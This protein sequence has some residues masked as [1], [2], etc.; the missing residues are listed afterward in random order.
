MRWRRGHGAGVIRGAAGFG[1]AGFGAAGFAA[2]GAAFGAAFFGAA[3]A[4]IAF[5]GFAFA[6][7]L[8]PSPSP[9]ASSSLRRSSWRCALNRTA[10]GLCHR[11]FDLRFFDLLFFA[12]IILLL[13]IVRTRCESSPEKVCCH[14]CVSTGVSRRGL[15]RLPRVS[16]TEPIRPL[17]DVWLRPRRVF[18]ELATRPIGAHR[19]LVGSGTRHRHLRDGVSNAACRG[20]MPARRKSSAAHCCSGPWAE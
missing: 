12:M 4:L 5:L 6:A 11:R 8:S 10:F 15:R 13:K 2:L 16:T 3:F 1:A 7:D 19:L 18:R 20:Y 14:L 17:K 9:A